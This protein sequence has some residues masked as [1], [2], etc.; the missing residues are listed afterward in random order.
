MIY[1]HELWISTNFFPQKR[2]FLKDANIHRTFAK[3][4]EKL[5]RLLLERC[6]NVSILGRSGQMLQHEP[7]VAKTIAL[8]QP[9][10]DLPN[11]LVINQQRP[12]AHNA[13]SIKQLYFQKVERRLLRRTVAEICASIPR[14]YFPIENISTIFEFVL[15][16]SMRRGAFE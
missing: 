15:R 16:F 2:F 1:F 12:L 11:V 14:F 4:E 9:R 6:K 3:L 13:W 8:I 7:F 10:T 5:Q